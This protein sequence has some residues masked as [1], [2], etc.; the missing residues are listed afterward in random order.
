MAMAAPM[1]GSMYPCGVASENLRRMTS[2]A[3]QALIASSPSP[4]C[5]VVKPTHEEVLLNVLQAVVAESA[6]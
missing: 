2:F 6:G 4:C 5:K 1:R 3:V